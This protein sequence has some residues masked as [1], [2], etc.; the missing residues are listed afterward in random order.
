MPFSAE[1]TIG[2]S[3]PPLGERIISAGE[4]FKVEQKKRNFIRESAKKI[5]KL[6]TTE[7]F[8]RF[9]NWSDRGAIRHPEFRADFFDAYYKCAQTLISRVGKSKFENQIISPAMQNL[10]FNI[11][12]TCQTREPQLIKLAGQDIG[13][14]KLEQTID[15]IDLNEQIIL[16]AF[17]VLGHYALPLIKEQK[18]AAEYISDPQLKAD[19]QKKI[20][21]ILENMKRAEKSKKISWQKFDTA[22]AA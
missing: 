21:I 20:Q 4:L 3:A 13:N 9:L 8:G 15:L 17:A 22:I 19:L 14:I 2:Q 6:Q 1:Q 18:L 5:T 11:I 10:L 12:K 16:N 7:D